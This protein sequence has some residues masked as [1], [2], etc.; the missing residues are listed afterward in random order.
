MISIIFRTS[1][2]FISTFNDNFTDFG[3]DPSGL[4]AIIIHGWL[5]STNH[6]TWIPDLIGNLS[7]FRGGCILTMDYFNYSKLGYYDMYY[8]FD[9]ISNVLLMKVNQLYKE[10][11]KPENGYMFG[12][13]F[14]SHLVYDV[15]IKTGGQIARIDSKILFWFEEFKD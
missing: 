6:T 3:C 12:F 10:G 2:P 13:S 1:K 7:A 15:G 4:W 14:G 5:E 11:F 8:Q 9:G